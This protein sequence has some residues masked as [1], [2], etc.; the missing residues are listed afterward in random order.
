MA[1]LYLH[2]N[3]VDHIHWGNNRAKPFQYPVCLKQISNFTTFNLKLRVDNTH[4]HG[5]G[6]T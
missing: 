4:K 3:N 2:I 6:M 1:Y 5:I